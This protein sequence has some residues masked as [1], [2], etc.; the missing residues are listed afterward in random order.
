M[1]ICKNVRV[2]SGND[3]E[4]RYWDRLRAY[5]QVARFQIDEGYNNDI[6]TIWRVD[7]VWS[8]DNGEIEYRLY[9]DYEIAR[10]TAKKLQAMGFFTMETLAL[11]V[12]EYVVNTVVD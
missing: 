4:Q 3:I 12:R 1:G 11:A 10:G 5:D 2:E 8:N 6:V 9:D 7:A